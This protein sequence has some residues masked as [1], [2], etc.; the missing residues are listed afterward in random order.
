M[1]IVKKY[2]T[3]EEKAPMGPHEKRKYEELQVEYRLLYKL[4]NEKERELFSFMDMYVP[5][6]ENKQEE[7][8]PVWWHETKKDKK[9]QMVG[10]RK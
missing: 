9:T 7:P 4:L 1:G 8:L 10:E 6:P 3:N 2:R 5:I